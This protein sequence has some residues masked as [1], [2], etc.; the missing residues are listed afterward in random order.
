[1]TA[2]DGQHKAVIASI[3]V[4]P[5][6]SSNAGPRID[7]EE[8]RMKGARDVM[9]CARERTVAEHE[10]VSEEAAALTAQ[11]A[12]RV[13][14][15]EEAALAEDRCRAEQ[16]RILN[17]REAA[18][19]RTE[20][21]WVTDREGYFIEQGL[22]RRQWQRQQHQKN[23]GVSTSSSY[24]PPAVSLIERG[25]RRR[26][27]LRHEDDRGRGDLMDKSEIGI[28]VRLPFAMRLATG[29]ISALE[30]AAI[31]AADDADNARDVDAEE[32]D[33]AEG[34]QSEEGDVVADE[35]VE[36]DCRPH[37]EASPEDELERLSAALK[38]AKEDVLR[39]EAIRASL[40]AASELLELV[41]LLDPPAASASSAGLPQ[42]KAV[43][44]NVSKS[45]EMRAIDWASPRPG[46]TP[47]LTWSTPCPHLVSPGPH[48][49]VRSQFGSTQ[50][51]GRC[52]GR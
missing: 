21:H 49:G 22:R 14:D 42:F 50:C 19:D 23:D 25:L 30:L 4:E 39:F 40:A 3:V 24:E 10:A 32:G 34:G 33:V 52:G 41:S 27:R 15:E 45:K 11:M 2:H 16:E 7:D 35:D 43:E 9:A 38:I 48:P 31:D 28:A 44:H 18:R 20:P 8:S 47:G 17:L 46:Y 5:G 29:R 12:E 6:P 13:R 36:D 26:Q 51:P 1:M 37:Q